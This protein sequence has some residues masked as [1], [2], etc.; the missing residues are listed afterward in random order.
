MDSW[1]ITL[2]PT[3]CKIRKGIL[4]DDSGIARLNLIFMLISK[5]DLKA[6]LRTG[7]AHK[8]TLIIKYLYVIG[9]RSLERCRGQ[10]CQTNS[11]EK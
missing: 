6:T 10:F 8:K 3:Y 9:R 4:S 7:I 11:H 2:R 1:L 5:S